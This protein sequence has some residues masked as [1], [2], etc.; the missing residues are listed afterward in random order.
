[1]KGLALEKLGFVRL[2]GCCSL[3]PGGCVHA[4]RDRAVAWNNIWQGR[5]E[6]TSH[7]KRSQGQRSRYDVPNKQWL[8][9]EGGYEE[10]FP[11]L[12]RRQH[13]E[14]RK[15]RKDRCWSRVGSCPLTQSLEHVEGTAVNPQVWNGGRRGRCDGGMADGGIDG[16]A[17]KPGVQAL[18]LPR[19]ALTLVG[20]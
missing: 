8:D 18:P 17:H 16:L 19:A 1:M 6:G 15:L 10:C 14:N 20:C 4:K 12:R 11:S 7:E 9:W 13:A 5:N 3:R 2:Q